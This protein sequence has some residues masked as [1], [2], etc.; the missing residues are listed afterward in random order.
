MRQG[1]VKTFSINFIYLYGENDTPLDMGI[2][3]GVSKLACKGKERTRLYDTT[4]WH[5]PYIRQY[6]F[7]AMKYLIIN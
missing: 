4:V 3:S 2:G 1:A 7:Y 6:I 5:Q